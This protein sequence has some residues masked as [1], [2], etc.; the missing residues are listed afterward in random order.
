MTVASGNSAITGSV[1]N[2]S[3]LAE[4]GSQATS[5]SNF[6]G[7]VSN[8]RVIKGTALY[9]SDFTIPSAPLTNVTNTKL[10]CCQSDS[11]AT[12][13]NSSSSHTITAN[14][15]AAATT[16]SD[17]VNLDLLADTPGAP[18]DNGA[19]GGANY[20]TL[21]PLDSGGTLS[22]GNL[23]VIGGG[24]TWKSSR[25]TF[26]MPSGKWY[27]E[28]TVNDD[29]YAHTV[30]IGTDSPDLLGFF[31]GYS[32]GYAY[33]TSGT[34]YNNNSS[35]S[36]GDSWLSTGD[37]IGVAFD[38]DGGNLYFYKNGVVQDSGTAAFTGL[39]SE[40][41]FPMI[42]NNASTSSGSM[43]FG[44][45][46]FAYTPP[47]GYKALN[48]FN[49]DDPTIA[50]PSL[51]FDTKLYTGNGDSNNTSLADG[52][53]LTT[54]FS[55]DLVWIKRR[56][57]AKSH[58]IHDT[59]RGERGR[60]FSDRTDDEEVY[61]HDKISFNSTGIQIKTNDDN[62][63]ANNDTYVS[64]MWDAGSS[65]VTNTDGSIT[66]SVRANTTTGFSIAKYT[67][68]NNSSDQSF[69]HSL[70]VK[71]DLV[72][73]K[74]LDKSSNWDIYHSSLGYNASLIFTNAATRSGA[75]SAEPTS[76]VV[77]TKH[78]Y[79]H[80]TTKSYSAYCWSEVEGY[81]KFGSYLGNNSTDGPFVYCGFKPRWVMV[82]STAANSGNWWIWDSEREPT[83]AITIPLYANTTA[84]ETSTGTG[85]HDLLSNGFKFRGNGG[86]YNAAYTYI[87]C[88]F[89]ESPM[90]NLYGA[91]SNAR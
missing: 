17:G 57:T 43:N 47:T 3:R 60:L 32:G 54:S 42:G 18:Y 61:G 37:T 66:S 82:K 48:V 9:T 29:T 6:L 28:Y 68:P 74:A 36:Y 83:N 16:K 23:D 26:A 10:L 7:H 79:T 22:N 64:W 34:K 40:T 84:A 76:T 31:G 33:H 72:I 49:L 87:F 30:G 73:V 89:A 5:G 12:T 91:Q 13:D 65:T 14:G 35:S 81:S 21:N 86:A 78:D 62:Y 69:G 55:P 8:L 85:A 80:Y 1:Y 53:I 56:N 45:R 77:N 52:P 44:Q 58:A 4:V 50:D 70:G 38:A 2:S 11:S 51:Y 25:A 59:I 90:N 67:S 88:A 46:A 19:N 20:A 71:P 41:Y 39:T 24:G 75:F 63:N 15:D 27:F